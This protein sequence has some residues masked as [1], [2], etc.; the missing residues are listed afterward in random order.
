[1]KYLMSLREEMDVAMRLIKNL[2]TALQTE[3]RRRHRPAP[4]C[5]AVRRYPTTHWVMGRVTARFYCS[6]FTAP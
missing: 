6:S 3:T 2:F 5:C 4:V 1:M